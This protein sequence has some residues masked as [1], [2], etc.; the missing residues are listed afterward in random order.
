MQR[1]LLPNNW[2]RPKINVYCISAGRPSS[3]PKMREFNVNLTWVVPPDEKG[4]YAAYGATVI[5]ADGLCG[6]RNLALEKSKEEDS[7]CIQISDDLKSIKWFTGTEKVP[8]P[9]DKAIGHM[10]FSG[11]Q[12]KAKLVGVA[13]TDNSYF[14]REDYS[15]RNF[16]VGDLIAVAPDSPL[17]FDEKLKLKEDYDYTCQNLARYGVA[18]R[19]NRIMA[20]FSHRTNRGGAVAVRSPELEQESIAY[21]KNK[22][23]DVVRDNPRRENEILLKW[24]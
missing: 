23:G 5:T 24:K 14:F 19:V 7:W 9:L 18:L 17:R 6:A 12:L 21:L 15:S 3:V 4:E 16:I 2:N 1:A 10:V 8:M 22:W 13:P 11:T 20:S